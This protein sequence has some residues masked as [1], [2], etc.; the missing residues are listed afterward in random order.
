MSGLIKPGARIV[1]NQ[2]VPEGE[3]CFVEYSTPGPNAT[4]A[5]AEVL[6]Q[7]LQKK[8]RA[9]G[10]VWFRVTQVLVGVFKVEGWDHKPKGA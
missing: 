8:A 1:D 2:G 10:A 3:P 4:L 5:D 7:G 9:S 6:M